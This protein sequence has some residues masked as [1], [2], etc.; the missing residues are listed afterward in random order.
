MTTKCDECAEEFEYFEP[1]PNMGLNKDLFIP[2]Y[3]ESCFDKQTEKVRQD[4][5]IANKEKLENDFWNEVPKE[6]FHDTSIG[7]LNAIIV[8]TINSWK[9]GPKG[10]GMM[11][12]SG[13]GKTRAA[14]LILKD[15]H[16]LGRSI[17]YMKAVKLTQYARDQFSDDSEIRNTARKRIKK[18]Y[19]CNL[20][21]LDDIGKGRLTASAEELL[22]DIIDERSEKGLPIIWT[23]NASGKE[24]H[25]MFSLDKADAILRRLSEFSTV[26]KV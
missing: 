1:D 17:C 6:L 18:T 10:L 3:C 13:E 12:K 15:N 25:A 2:R 9:H 22:F 11:G 4:I 16:Y 21:L 19:K 5:I 23:S 26:V 20:L 24:L 14:V 8:S 7:R